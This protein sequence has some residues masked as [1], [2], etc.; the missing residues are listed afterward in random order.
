MNLKLKVKM[1]ETGI[2]QRALSHQL[3]IDESRL[4]RIVNGWS[5]PTPQEQTEIAEA[6]NSQASEL[7]REVQHV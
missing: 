1:F 4:S 5:D 7:F 6:L 2:S 3:A